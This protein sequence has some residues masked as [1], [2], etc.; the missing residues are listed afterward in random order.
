MQARRINLLPLLLFLLATPVRAQT[1]VPSDPRRGGFHVTFTDQSPLS[2][3]EAQNKRH[4]IKVDDAQ[5]YS[6]SD[7]SFEAY[8]PEDYDPDR[9]WGLLVWV[10]AAETGAP[11]RSIIPLL[12]QHQLIWIG[13]NNSGNERGVGVRFGLALD[14]VHNMRKLYNIDDSR[15]YVSG[16]SGGG[17]VSTML[18]IIYPE[19]FVG[20]IPIVGV[21][22]FRHIPISGE[23]GKFWQGNFE[24]PPKPTL[25]RAARDG[26]F[27]FIT[28]SEDFNRQS[29]QDTLEQGFKKDGF[30]HIEYVEI[31]GMKHQM[32]EAS[33]FEKAI[34]TLDAP[35]LGLAKEQYEQA[36]VLETNGKLAEAQKLYAQASAHG[37]DQLAPKAEEKLSALLQRRDEQVIRAQ[38]LAEE[39]RYVEAANLLVELIRQFGAGAP[40]EAN[41]LLE[42]LKSDPDAARQIRAAAAQVSA[43][44][45]EADANG[46]L[47]AARAL[48]ARDLRRGYA[49]MKKIPTD[50]PGTKAAAQAQLEAA[51]L[52]ADPNNKRV[53][54]TDPKEEEAAKILLLAENYERNQL[55][56]E[57][58]DRCDKILKEFPNTKSAAKAKQMIERIKSEQQPGR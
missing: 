8:V 34:E 48:V 17:K 45:R 3:I 51:N 14:A 37:G 57:A 6:L 42:K 7:E 53:I 10:H 46:A 27:V 52:V 38:R 4:H 36:Q 29:I 41:E 12:S 31:P 44:K 32:P 55:Y 19:V 21:T 15:I 56:R 40:P 1:T 24:K 22:Y 35:L 50:F 9:P 18:A 39:K 47:D 26:R 54:D 28:G 58:R 11:P 20:A 30:A 13:A 33:V 25:E 49:A 2:P 16:I 5:R 43:E 23:N